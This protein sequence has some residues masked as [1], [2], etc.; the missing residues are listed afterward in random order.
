MKVAKSWWSLGLMTVAL[1]FGTL[2]AGELDLLVQEL[3][4]KGV[5]EPGR[6]QQILTLTE[7]EMRKELAKGEIA[8]LPQWLQ[9]MG[10]K[11]DFRLR[12]QW[13]KMEHDTLARMRQRIRF[14]LTGEAMVGKEVKVGFGLATGSSDP[15]STNQTLENSFETKPIM[16]DYA[17]MQYE[18]PARVTVIGGK[19]YNN[20]A[21]WSPSD[22]IWDGDIALEGLA[23]LWNYRRYFLNTGL[24]ILDEAGKVEDVIRDN[25]R[26]L[27]VQPGVKLA[28]E[29]VYE[30]QAAVTYYGFNGVKDKAFDHAKWSNTYYKIGSSKYLT[31]GYNNLALA[32]EAGFYEKFFPYIG[33]ALEYNLNLQVDSANT[34]LAFGITLGHKKVSQKGQWSIKYQYRQLAKDAWLD[35]L[36]D[37]DTYSGKT[38]VKGNKVT[39]QYAMRP[40]L[41]CA[42]NYFSNANLSGS[43][44]GESLVQLDIQLKF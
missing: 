21:F 3:V 33:L 40:N 14:R 7:E 24:Y 43:V 41:V 23:G 30:F 42:V 32:A 16:L 35:F 17:Y 6:A 38:D 44:V 39:F 22:Y 18:L 8:T 29:E 4:A 37:S 36:P 2:R 10:L 11:G 25:P 13:E 12:N 20:Q 27:V 5:L 28:R 34:G 31:Y 19:F 9:K 1:A 26:L 15:R